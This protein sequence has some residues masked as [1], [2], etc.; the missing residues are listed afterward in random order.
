M[1][2]QGPPGPPGPPGHPGYSR[3]FATY[4]NITADLMDFFRSKQL[5]GVMKNNRHFMINV[6]RPDQITQIKP[7]MFNVAGDLEWHVSKVQEIKFKFR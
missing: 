4:G 1:G 3:V 7:K 5:Y 6:V 2:I